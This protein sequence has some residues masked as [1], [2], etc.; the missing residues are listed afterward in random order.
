ME[1][2]DNINNNDL[3]ELVKMT[4]DLSSNLDIDAILNK[5][6]SSAGRLVAAEGA[7]VMLFD[8]EKQYLRFIAISGE[9]A[10]ILRRMTVNEGVA[11]NVAQSGE[12]DIVNDTD[13]DPRFTGSVDKVTD[14]TTRSLLAVPITFDGETLGVLE[15][16]NKMAGAKF[17]EADKRLF[18]ILSDQIAIVIKNAKMAEAQR[19]F[20]T[21]SIEIFVKSI[22]SVG[23][24]MELMSQGHC[25]QVAA[26]STAM[27]QDFEISGPSFDDLYYGAVLHDIGILE[28]QHDESI[29]FESFQEQWDQDVW[30]DIKSHPVA[31]ANIIK[32]IT[33]LHGTAPIIRHHHEHF[34]GTGYP[35]GLRGDNIPLGARIVAVAEMYEEM[36]L[37]SLKTE[38]EMEK[39]AIEGIRKLSDTMLDPLVVDVFLS[40]MSA[41]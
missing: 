10:N 25:W 13:S 22:E 30:G 1:E 34:D 3:Q 26:L 36:L 4:T 6:N 14:F 12:A 35:D 27:G 38:S 39:I 18:T 17:T 41:E 8:D 23:V 29:L 20:F 28:Q 19:N 21:N 31:G 15:A 16:V 7:S 33:L 11:W 2:K 9:K 37:G 40:M 24:M 5:I 32:N